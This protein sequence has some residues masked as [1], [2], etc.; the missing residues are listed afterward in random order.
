MLSFFA[1][2]ESGGD[3]GALSEVAVTD[4]NALVLLLLLRTCCL[5]HPLAFREVETSV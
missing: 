5:L 1:P 4:L 2:G 3:D